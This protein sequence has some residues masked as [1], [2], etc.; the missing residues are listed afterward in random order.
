MLLSF[1]PVIG[2]SFKENNDPEPLVTYNNCIVW[3]F[4]NTNNVNAPF[5]WIFGIYL[6]LFKKNIKVEA[7]NEEGEKLNVFVRGLDGV[8]L[9]SWLSKE[10]LE[11]RLNSATGILFWAG[12]S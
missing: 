3:I 10:Q 5:T 4:G 6:A 7:K 2:E 8:E 9:G 11:V 1:Q 12:K